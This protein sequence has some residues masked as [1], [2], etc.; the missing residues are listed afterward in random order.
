MAN[1][2]SVLRD[3]IEK[4]AMALSGKNKQFNLILI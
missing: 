4:S 3:N 2:F 1:D